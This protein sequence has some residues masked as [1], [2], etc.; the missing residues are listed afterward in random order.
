MSFI[1]FEELL[2]KYFDNADQFTVVPKIVFLDVDVHALNSFLMRDRP[3]EKFIMGKKPSD[4]M[5]FCHF[6]YRLPPIVITA[7]RRSKIIGS[8]YGLLYRDVA[9]LPREIYMGKT[10]NGEFRDSPI[11]CIEI[12]AKQGFL[13]CDDD[14]DA[15]SVNKCRYCY[16]Q[17]SECGSTTSLQ[18]SRSHFSYQYLKLKNDRIERVSSYCPI[19]LF[20]GKAERMN[21]ALKGVID[22]PQNNLKV[23][24]DGKMVYNEYTSDMNSLRRVLLNLFPDT[25]SA[26]K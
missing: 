21:Q 7:V 15:F 18:Y 24:Q 11:I 4:F 12:K 22:N 3:G 1:H 14:D 23:F 19:D 6:Q 8:N 5:T 20:S 26:E 17:V 13:M 2:Q 10:V 16:F 9:F 25:M